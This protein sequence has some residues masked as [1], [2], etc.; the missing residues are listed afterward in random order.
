MRRS[1]AEFSRKE[2]PDIPRS[3]Q[4]RGQR[5]GLGKKIQVLDMFL[6]NQE[7]RENALLAF[8]GPARP[9]GSR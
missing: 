5:L 4:L 6:W 7:N 2:L 1:S 8:E 9:P 3:S